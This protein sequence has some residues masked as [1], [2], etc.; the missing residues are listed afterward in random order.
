MAEQAVAMVMPLVLQWTDGVIPRHMLPQLLMI[1]GGAL[2]LL[3][4][5][6]LIRHQR[7]ASAAAADSTLLLVPDDQ[8]PGGR[9]SEDGFTF[10]GKGASQTSEEALEDLRRIEKDMRALRELYHAG[11]I[12]EASYVSESRSL[13]QASRKII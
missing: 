2:V 10:F 3:L 13:Y 9:E 6:L 4:V 7:L 5:V 1:V 11:E 12:S 8:R